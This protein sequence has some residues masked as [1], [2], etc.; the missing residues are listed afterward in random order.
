MCRAERFPIPLSFADEYAVI[1][2]DSYVN[3]DA[4][5]YYHSDSNG[6]KDPYTDPN[7]D[8][9]PWPDAFHLHSAWRPERE[10][11]SKSEWLP[12]SAERKLRR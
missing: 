12:V 4:E 6:D 7:C 9:A 5:P 11:Q 10:Q 8:P 2:S 1:D 3:G